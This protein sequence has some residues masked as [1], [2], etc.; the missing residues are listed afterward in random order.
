[1]SILS[2]IL[3]ATLLESAL[4]FSG[5]LFLILSEERLRKFLHTILS[6]AAG[7]L[8][9]VTFL[10]VLPEALEGGE[11]QLIM[12]WTLAS[13]V[14]FFI[15]EKTI[16][17]Y[18]HHED[19]CMPHG[20]SPAYLVLVGDIL[21]NV[22]DG[23]A[24]ALSFMIGT[25]LGIA[26]TIA[27]LIHEIPTEMGDFMVLLQSGFSRFRALLYN[28]FIS[29]STIVAALITYAFGPVLEPYLPL[30]LALVAGNFLYIAIADV[31][32]ELQESSGWKH[33][34][35]EIALFIVGIFVVSIGRWFE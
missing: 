24:I 26:T 29:L 34:M 33:S 22:V 9:G 16:R 31:I 23:V 13:I 21:H 30:A 11:T 15:I 19:G 12:G 14:L 27:V 25:E 8:L 4:S 5:V 1:M 3:L 32:P 10:E 18:H 6:F 20:H 28:F 17:W 7:A 35:A 2:S